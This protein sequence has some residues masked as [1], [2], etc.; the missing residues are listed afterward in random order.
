M[1]KTVFYLLILIIASFGGCYSDSNNGSSLF[2]GGI[3]SSLLNFQQDNLTREEIQ[4][5]D[6]G[7][8]GDYDSTVKDFRKTMPDYDGAVAQLP[9]SFSWMAQ[10]MV[11][12]AKNQG[13]CGS[14]WAF[15]AAGAFES[16]ILMRGGLQYDLSELQQ[17][18]CNTSM[19][20]CSGGNMAAL[21]YWYTA[22][23]K[24]ESCTGYDYYNGSCNNMSSCLMLSY[25]T[26]GYYTVAT[27]S[28]N[29]I[30]TSLSN[31]GPGYFRFDVYSDFF[32]YWY[33]AGNGDVYKQQTGAYDG[34]HAV[35][36]I[37]WDDIK[38]AWLCKNSWGRTGGPN[39]D[40]TFWIAYT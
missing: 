38:E 26:S 17:V 8:P 3:F 31:D 21:K 33:S 7:I 18:L 29:E 30:K 37:G 28:I 32:D 34:G 12:P 25:R 36:I 20:G 4:L 13:S 5:G 9:A 39:G 14:C 19:G 40:G 11:T 1:K 22:G 27:S 35:E 6:L 24:E 10:G 23:P 16:K 2:S 15:A